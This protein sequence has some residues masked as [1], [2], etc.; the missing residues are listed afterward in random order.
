[1]RPRARIEAIVTHL[2]GLGAGKVLARGGGADIGP[3][4]KLGVPVM[5]LVQEVEHYFDYHHTEADTL[6]KVDPHDLNRNLAAMMLMAYTLAEMP[7][8][9]PRLEPEALSP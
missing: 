8:T 6:D 9:L 5:G 1:M 7:D 2:E 3:L 4:K